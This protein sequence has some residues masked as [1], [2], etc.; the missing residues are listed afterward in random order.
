MSEIQIV[1][2]AQVAPIALANGSWTKMLVTR[3]YV[4]GNDTALGF[5]LFTAGTVTELVAHEV[6][7]LAFVVEGHGELRR[8]VGAPVPFSSG[9]AIFIPRRAWHAV[10]NPSEGDLTMVCVFPHPTYPPTER[11]SAI[12]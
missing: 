6:E 7:E 5:S 4:A 12:L 1:P 10:A 11:R 9:D 2:L 3:E 8:E